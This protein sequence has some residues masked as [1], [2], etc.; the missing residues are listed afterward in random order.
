[1]SSW[2]FSCIAVFLGVESVALGKEDHYRTRKNGDLLPGR[3]LSYL[4][5]PSKVWRSFFISN[6]CLG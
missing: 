3:S 6:T 1:M 2:L 4:G 5:L